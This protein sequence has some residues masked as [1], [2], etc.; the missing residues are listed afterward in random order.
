M[1]PA[2]GVPCTAGPTDADTFK[3]SAALI[4]GP[5]LAAYRVIN[6]ADGKGSLAEILDVPALI[7]HLRDQAGAVQGGSLAAPEAMLMNQATAL[8]SLFARLVESGMGQSLRANTEMFLK[9]G[10]R[11][12]NQCRATL[13]TLA[14]IKNP[15]V[16]FAKQANITNGPQ[17]VNNGIDAPRVREN[18]IEQT[19]LLEATP[20][21]RLDFGEKAKASGTNQAMATVGAVHRAKDNSGQKDSFPERI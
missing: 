12:Q 7:D 4:C 9:L 16:V 10:L 3:A 21:E 6:A 5:E 18:K 14:A 15:P 2:K 8:Q 20:N 11:A 13:E 19:K 1:R 17:Q